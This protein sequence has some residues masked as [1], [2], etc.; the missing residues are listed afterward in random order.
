MKLRNDLS[1]TDKVDFLRTMNEL[2][3]E[4]N[5]LGLGELDYADL[6]ICN[7][8]AKFVSTYKEIVSQAAPTNVVIAYST[9][10]FSLVSLKIIKVALSYVH[11]NYDVYLYGD[12]G[13][14]AE[15][16]YFKKYYPD[17]KRFSSLRKIKKLKGNTIL[18]DSFNPI[19]NVE[20]RMD[21]SKEFNEIF[22]PLRYLRPSTLQ[23][24]YSFYAPEDKDYKR[25][26]EGNSL[27][28][29]TG[30]FDDFERFYEFPD[31][32]KYGPYFYNLKE[33]RPFVHFVL[34]DTEASYPLFSLIW[35]SAK[36]GNIHLYT[37]LGDDSQIEHLGKFL[38]KYG[39]D[40]NIPNPLN[41]VTLDE[42]ITMLQMTESGGNSVWY[43]D[44]L[45][46]A[47]KE[48]SEN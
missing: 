31:K 25:I 24:I 1:L 15:K 44:D 26:I 27:K 47:R 2:N 40:S 32:V 8:A 45:D 19:V 14:K 43:D 22:Q 7:I 41:I 10:V 17:I 4:Y 23:N 35:E 3:F 34:D 29:V 42:A 38:R 33:S 12:F 9:D 16:D 6:S 20:S 18:I 36:E 21:Y 39:F 11:G 13:T 28:F 46:E 5:H 37:F 30:N 48:L